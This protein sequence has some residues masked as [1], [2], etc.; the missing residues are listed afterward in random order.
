M[1]ITELALLARIFKAQD[2]SERLKACKANLADIRNVF[3]VILLAKDLHELRD[4]S[5]QPRA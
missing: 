4:D 2:F 1:N 3:P 5:K